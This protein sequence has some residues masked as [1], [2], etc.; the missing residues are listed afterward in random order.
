MK[1]IVIVLLSLVMVLSL[2]GCGRDKDSSTNQKTQPG[3]NNVISGDES[4]SGEDAASCG[5]P[6]PFNP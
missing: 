6:I 3:S 1:K 5:D 2:V 4:P